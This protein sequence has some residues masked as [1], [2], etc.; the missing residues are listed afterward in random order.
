MKTVAIIQ[1]RTGS[2]RLPNKVMKSILRKSMLLRVCERVRMAS[3][4][5]KIVVA[6]T[7]LKEDDSIEQLCKDNNIKYYRGSVNNVF[8]RYLEIG[9]RMNVDAIVRITSDCPLIDPTVINYV[10]E[11][12]IHNKIEYHGA[13]NV[14]ERTYP[15]GLDV[16][17]FSLYAFEELSYI[18]D[19]DYQFEHVTAGFYESKNGFKIYSVVN[20][21]ENL[22][23]LRW[24]V[25]EKDD[26]KFVREIYSRFKDNPF[27]MEDILEV[28][29]RS[30][31]LREINTH[32][33][34]HDSFWMR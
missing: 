15:R 24:T 10:I 31:K 34:Q 23:H 18:I 32:I 5:D 9:K 11:S 33:K 7:H 21:G 8:S 2:T 13:S 14:I 6:T 3:H 20:E 22:S 27:I 26:L 25:D 30:P 4:I 1:A 12:Y 17:V 19:K 29:K 16:E 28:L